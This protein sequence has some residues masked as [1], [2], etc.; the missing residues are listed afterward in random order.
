MMEVRMNRHTV[1]AVILMASTAATAAPSGWLSVGEGA[2]LQLKAAGQRAAAG[3]HR[4][5]AAGPGEKVYLLKVRDSE[6]PAIAAALHRGLRHCGGYMYHA[7]EAAARLA[8]APRRADP[9]AT[10]PSYLIANQ[11]TVVPMLAQMDAGRI[12]ESILKLSG[13]VNRYYSSTHGAEASNWLRADWAAAAASHPAVSVTQFTHA[14]YAQQSV[15]ATIAGTDKAAEVVVLGAHLDSINITSNREAA[16][17]PGA[18]DDGSGVA[19]LGEVLRAFAATNY[20]PRRT[21]KLIAYAAEEVGLRGSQDLA[22]D[23]AKNKVNV[24]GALQLDMSNY[25]GSPRDIYLI[26]D[27]TDAAQN[28]FLARLLAA[29]LPD[30]QVGTDRCGYAC[31]DHA[32]W[33]A[34]GYAASMPFEAMLAQD[35]PHIH[36]QDDTYAN[37]GKQ[38]LQALKFARMAAAYAVELGSDSP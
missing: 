21:I 36:T 9:L 18:D 27:Y 6:L 4:P 19:G 22:R 34:Q 11:A 38:A 2:Y 24:V 25:K 13:F 12:E 10:R 1:A 8:L 14:G 3:V 29:Y 26:G 15:I 20:R 16:R 33:S 17:A 7:S 35:N 37:S 23:F 5:A 28:G 31:S 30:V 32:S